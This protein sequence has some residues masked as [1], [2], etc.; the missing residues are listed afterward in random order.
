MVGAFL[1]AFSALGVFLVKDI[2]VY[3]G[4]QRERRGQWRTVLR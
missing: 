2:L 1:G 4:L 3:S